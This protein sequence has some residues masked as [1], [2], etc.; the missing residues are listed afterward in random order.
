MNGLLNFISQRDRGLEELN[1]FSNSLMVFLH[2]RRPLREA[3]RNLRLEL[4]RPAEGG[5][6]RP[7][8]MEKIDVRNW[9]ISAVHKAEVLGFIHS[10]E[11]GSQFLIPHL[12][13]GHIPVE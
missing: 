13:L 4:G 3:L 12:C 10:I 11:R 2:D 7:K 9:L 5:P 8:P 1:E 6:G